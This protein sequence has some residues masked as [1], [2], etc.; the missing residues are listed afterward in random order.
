MSIIACPQCAKNVSSRAALCPHCGFEL[1]EA[2]EEDYAIYRARRLR[3]RIYRLN[4]ISYAVIT[5]FVAGFGWYWWGSRGFTQATHAGPFV[6]M[7]VAALGYLVT[8]AF[9]FDARRKRRKMRES[10]KLSEGLR[11]KP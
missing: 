3:D 6:L 1:G 7:A 5:A 9:L 10:R 8:R 11:N 4:M 2:N